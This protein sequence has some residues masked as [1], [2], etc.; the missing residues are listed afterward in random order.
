M[1]PASDRRF[2]LKQLSHFVTNTKTEHETRHVV[3]LLKASTILLPPPYARRAGSAKFGCFS[4]SASSRGALRGSEGIPNLMIHSLVS[5]RRWLMAILA[6]VP[7]VIGGKAVAL[8]NSP[9]KVVVRQDGDHWQLHRNGQ[10]F[11]IKG[12]GGEGSL[13]RLKEA[14]A[15][16]IRTWDARR[17]EPVLE[18]AQRLGLTVCV[19]IW[20]HHEGDTEGF[21]YSKPDM[22]RQQLERVEQYVKRFKDHP[23]V[24]LW[25]LG[26]EM[27]GFEA[28]NK[29][30]IWIAVEEAAKRVKSL[31][32][33]HPTM[34]VIS[35][36]GGERIACIHRYC[37]SI[38]IIGINSY[39]GSVS[40]AERYVRLNGTKPYI[41]TEFGPP[42]PWEV[43][44][45]T[46]DAAYEPTSTEKGEWYRRAY[47][48]SIQQKPLC[49]GSYA[50]LWGH[51]QE[52]TT[53]WYGMFLKDGDK[54]QAVDTMTELWTGKPPA[55]PSPV[56]KGLRIRFRQKFT[57]GER[58]FADLDASDA[59]GRPLQVRWLVQPEQP[60]KLTAGAEEQA[61]PELTNVIVRSDARFSE[62]QSPATPGGYRLF[63]Y[64]RNGAGAAVANVP[65][66]VIDNKTAAERRATLPFVIYSDQSGAG[67]HYVPSGW[68][69]N[70]KAIKMDVGCRTRPHSG[71]TC[72]SVRYQ[73]SAGWGAVAWQDPPEDWGDRTGGWDLT[74]AKEL[75]FWARG[76]KGGEEVD[77]K[78]GILGRDKSHPDSDNG[79]L[80]KVRLTREWK[81]YR[82]N[83]AGKD[84]S[85]IKTG[86]CWS[87]KGQNQP[88]TFYLDDIQYE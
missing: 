81:Q 80:E 32:P 52:T 36:L 19:G 86:F 46:W 70:L 60:N 37:P 79:A 27:E 75:T 66:Y 2:W 21:D 22:V 84:L 38:D 87:L 31:D 11:F 24:L 48:G 63:A 51:K 76:E 15:N 7:P 25:S 35:E 47:L 71:T 74:G 39:A 18:E 73:D 67:S 50:F 20:L 42:G 3:A 68:M 1:Q 10:P 62:V 61:L 16:S 88:L 23:A 56:L 77:F 13:A 69:G 9:V 17:L 34:T 78:F 83:L 33:N 8:S 45:T 54:L 6:L 41:V 28:G 59:G 82:I 29:V 40:I 43:A 85:R 65:F 26:N 5:L 58:F 64:V 49:L 72:L 53:T 14:G 4:R 57:P 55:N 44:K 12:A 30:E